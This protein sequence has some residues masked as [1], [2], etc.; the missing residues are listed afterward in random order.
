MKTTVV[1]VVRAPQAHRAVLEEGLRTLAR[2]TRMVFARVYQRR[3]D[4]AH[5][6]RSVCASLGLLSRHYSG[7]R[8]DA[9]A[10][11]RGWRERLARRAA[12]APSQPSRGARGDARA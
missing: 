4:E 7:C 5:V 11:A 1:C 9:T 12:C 3:E 6:K 10:A 2:A 8:A